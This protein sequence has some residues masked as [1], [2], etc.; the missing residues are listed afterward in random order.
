MASRCRNAGSGG[1]E[2][3]QQQLVLSFTA[4]LLNRELYVEYNCDDGQCV[5]DHDYCNGMVGPMRG[6]NHS[7][8]PGV[9]Y[10]CR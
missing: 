6:C 5:T 3:A 9:Q 1:G 8:Y 10:N 7:E 2:D 4:C